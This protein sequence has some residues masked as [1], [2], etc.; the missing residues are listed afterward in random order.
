MIWHVVE[1]LD[2]LMFREAKPFS[3]GEG[4]W[5]KGLFPPMP[6]TVFQAMRSALPFD[7]LAKDEQGLWRLDFLGPFL[8]DENEKLW[9]PTP[10][11][12][13]C[14]LK[15]KEGEEEA[16]DNWDEKAVGATKRLRPRIESDPA[17]KSILLDSQIPGPMV[18]PKLEDREFIAGQPKPWISAPAL[19][20]YL[21][22][23][24]PSRPGD[25][26]DDPW[27]VQVMTH[28]KVQVGSRTVE[29]ED[30]YFTEVATRLHPGWRFVAGFS[31]KIERTAVRLGGEG[32][33][34]LVYPASS[35]VEKTWKELQED[36][37]LSPAKRFAYLLTPGLVQTAENS[38]V[39]S[40]CPDP[41][42]PGWE[43]WQSLKG[44]ATSRAIAW[45]GVSTNR[46]QGRIG[47]FSLLPQRAFVPPGTVYVFDKP[48]KTD[49]HLLPTTE[50]FKTFET[51]NYGKL[52]WG[53]R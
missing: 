23:I 11:D 36:G 49:R 35:S 43:D 9:L 10:K 33:R 8:I 31:K 2:I 41:Q 52:L 51:L 6:T 48:P 40:T 32:H 19:L 26:C 34:A 7:N 42:Q 44:C 17:W 30:S 22:G 3:P 4:A 38:A 46:K 1:P 53:K 37:K 20:D 25:F 18:S 21:Q 14:V 28:I 47:D 13:M 24:D 15:S 16:E 45:G 50:G 29:D 39:Y 12:L 27:D 5:A